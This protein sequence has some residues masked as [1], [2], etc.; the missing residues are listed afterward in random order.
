M[1]IIR[2]FNPKIAYFLQSRRKAFTQL[3]MP[4]SGK[5]VI[6]MHCASLGEFEQGR[7]V[8][9]AIRQQ[10]PDCWIY[11]SFF[12]PSGYNVKKNTPLADAVGYLPFDLPKYIDPWLKA[13]RPNLVIFVKYEFWFY[14]LQQLKKKQIQVL[15]ISAIFRPNQPFFAWW[16]GFA[17]RGLACFNHIFVQNT[18]SV[19]LLQQIGLEQR[20]TLAGDTRFDRVWQ[21]TQLPPALPNLILPFFKSD[22]NDHSQT[23]KVLI[24]GSTWPDDEKLLAMAFRQFPDNWKMVVVPH[25]ITWSHLQHIEQ[26]FSDQDIVR[27]SDLV[28]GKVNFQS[29][30]QP[31]K[32]LIIDTIGL[33]ANLYRLGQVTWIGGGFGAGIHNTLEAAAWGIPVCFG[34]NYKKFNE[35]VELINKGAAFSITTWQT[36]TDKIKEW[37]QHPENGEVAGASGKNYIAEQQGA[38][39]RIMNYIQDLLA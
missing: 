39:K 3:P 7:P 2:W 13:L 26:A 5:M 23:T 9:E 1:A 18:Q 12:S 25:E 21:F 35:A 6:W 30:K 36:L 11:L 10:Y 31:P 15:S 20:C 38:T 14:V 32:I 17:R 22:E 27:Y 24:A 8:L 33:L 34:P 19:Q 4:P 29:H 16:G 37:Q 28:S